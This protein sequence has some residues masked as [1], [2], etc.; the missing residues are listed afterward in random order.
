MR[1]LRRNKKPIYYCL[2]QEVQAPIYDEYGNENGEQYAVYSAPTA[3]DYNVSPA[4]G[5]SNTEQFGD[6]DDY[7]KVIVTCD[8]NCPITESSVLFID[9]EPDTDDS[10]GNPKYDYIVKRVAKSINSISIAVK[11]VTVS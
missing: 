4:T 8:M 2:L 7:D 9:K 11:K 5:Q 1:D 3:A 10:D 6:L